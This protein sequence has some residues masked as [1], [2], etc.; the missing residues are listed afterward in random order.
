VLAEWEAGWIAQWLERLDH[1]FYRAR[2]STP[3][4]LDLSPR[5][6]WRRQFFATFEDDRY[7]VL[8]REGIGVGSLL[9]ANDYPHHDS[10]WPHSRDVWA[11]I[12]AGVPEDEKR[13]ML[14]ENVAKLYGL[15]VPAQVEA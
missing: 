10:I 11:D 14:Y 6:Y 8:T 7:G 13:A 4:E 15:K 5:E 12:L 9:W 1:A 3:P 2:F